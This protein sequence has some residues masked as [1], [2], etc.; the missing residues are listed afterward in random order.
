MTNDRGKRIIRKLS[1]AALRA[2]ALAL[3]AGLGIGV[4]AFGS[5]AAK[6]GNVPAGAIPTLMREALV[7]GL[8][9]ATIRDGRVHVRAFGVADV[10]SRRPVD[11]G[12]VFEAASLSKPVFAY[13]VLKLVSD[14]RLDLDA[15]VGR[16][17]SDAKGALA[18]VTARQ[19]LSHTA[20]LANAPSGGVQLATPPAPPL[21]FSYSG[22]GFR[23]L[24]RVVERVTGQDLQSYMQRAVF[25][26]LGMAST[27]FVWREDYTVRKAFAH[28]YTGSSA[29]R[30]RMAQA[31]APSSLETTAGDY[32]RFLLA[33]VRGTGLSPTV[34]RQML[35]PQVGLEQGCTACLDRPRGTPLSSLSWG[36]GIGLAR[37]GERTYAW[38]WGD[39]QTMQTYAA[40]STD[41][42]RGVV[43]L[44]NSA[45][46]HA[47]AR[48]VATTILGEDA[49]GYAWVGSYGSY[50]DPDRRLTS[51]IVQ[52]GADAVSSQ[53]LA[54]SRA[55]LRLVAERL[56]EGRRPAEAATLLRRTAGR[57]D[58][59]PD[60]EALFAE[61]L[62]RAGK[63]YEAA[64][65]AQ[66]AKA[67]DPHNEQLGEVLERIAQGR[68]VIDPGTLNRFAGRYSS[69]F[70]PLTISS[71][72]RQL[73][74]TLLDQP[75][76]SMLPL[77]DHAF[78]MES[79]NVPIEFVQDANG[80]VSHAVVRA[81]GEIRLPR[82]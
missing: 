77:S 71:D 3:L 51:A 37:V 22:E 19:L 65:V 67:S 8:A 62:R 5:T 10:Q 64:M 32:A 81:G 25:A 15:P 46:G 42:Q 78:L 50:D 45:N 72:G 58:A 17:L 26:P 13:G 14:G 39:N 12:T 38:H 27:S 49:P 44:A 30:T 60:D 1:A 7:P 79:M 56:I 20:G 29:G 73:I 11:A 9:V 54:V 74:A 41:G 76:S 40:I 53:Q 28:G 34:A 57:S 21:R 75:S 70:G 4:P 33:A 6:R 69:P 16:Y 23:L 61:A 80:T 48:G 2:S 52:Q 18:L 82:L 66:R 31:Q 59:T 63:L 47:I 35:T 55:T 43:I 24:Q 36:L 68:R